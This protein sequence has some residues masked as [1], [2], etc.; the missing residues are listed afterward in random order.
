ME[1]LVIAH[2]S[3]P[4]AFQ[5]GGLISAAYLFAFLDGSC[6]SQ[7]E[8]WSASPFPPP[9]DYILLGLS[10][11]THPTWV[12][13]HDMAHSFIELHKPLHHDKVEVHEGRN[14][15]DRGFCRAAVHEITKN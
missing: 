10:I 7:K 12:A 14:V 11:M 8:H 15:K 5:P 2:C 4:V 9:V 3:F 6:G 13:L 1:L